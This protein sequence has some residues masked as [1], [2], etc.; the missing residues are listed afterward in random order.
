MKQYENQQ[1]TV[2]LAKFAKKINEKSLNHVK[3]LCYQKW[4]RI[5][6]NDLGP[7]RIVSRLSEI[8]TNTDD[9]NRCVENDFYLGQILGEK[10]LKI[11]GG[12]ISADM[13]FHCQDEEPNIKTYKDGQQINLQIQALL[14]H[15][16]IG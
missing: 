6:L 4:K 1:K 5:A 11:I 12:L 2:I 8:I 14:N 9:F 7:D 16:I 10:L 3:I 13:L 15:S